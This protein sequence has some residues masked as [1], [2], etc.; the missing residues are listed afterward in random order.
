M[1]G[2]SVDEICLLEMVN[3]RK[4]A[5]FIDRNSKTIFIEILGERE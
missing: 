4:L 2:S 1:S 5:R 3:E